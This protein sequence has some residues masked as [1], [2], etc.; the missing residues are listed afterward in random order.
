V[1]NVG[2]AI[3]PTL[4][5]ALHGFVAIQP[6]AGPARVAHV[7]HRNGD[8]EANLLPLS[9]YSV[10][11]PWVFPQALAIG[12]KVFGAWIQEDGTIAVQD[13]GGLNMAEIFGDATLPATTLSLLS[14]SNDLPAVMYTTQTQD[15]TLGAYVESPAHSRAEITECQTAPGG[16]VSSSVMSTQLPGLWLNNI[17]RF[18]EDYLTTGGATLLCGPAQCTAVT[19]EC[20]PEQDLAN[21]VRNVA[22]ATVQAD[23]TGVVYSV[24]ALPQ[25]APKAGSVTAAEAR[26]SVTLGRVDFSKDPPESLTIGGD[27]QGLMEV[28]RQDT[29]EE[30][31]FTGP[32][33]PAVGILPSQQVAIAW[34]QPNAAFTGTELHVQRYK[35]CLPEP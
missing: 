10:H 25:L 2:L 31:D 7:V 1:S 28:S 12:N 18:G 13:V 14:S 16:Y 3:D 29:G 5:L 24:I 35:M 23:V 33:W 34:I 15:G 21:S 9:S 8:T 6:L 30:R 20:D 11:S 32:D 26:L 17:T 19:D 22:G 4:G 27:A